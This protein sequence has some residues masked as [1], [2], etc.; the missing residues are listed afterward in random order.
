MWSIFKKTTYQPLVHATRLGVKRAQPWVFLVILIV[1][2]IAFRE[3]L[4]D[5]MKADTGGLI[6]VD[7]PE[8][9]SRERLVN[10]RFKQFAWLDGQLKTM[11]EQPF[12][13]QVVADMRDVY[14]AQAKVA[15]GA[16]PQEKPSGST[17]D[18]QQDQVDQARS[19]ATSS[20]VEEFRD[21]LVYREEI[22][23]EIMETLLD[24]RHDIKGNTL[25]RLKFDTSIIPHRD[26]NSWAIVLVELSRS[27]HN[28]EDQSPKDMCRQTGL[29]EIYE[30]WIR[31]TERS[32]LE[33]LSNRVK[34][35]R[36]KNATAE[37][38]LDFYR[39]LD[40]AVTK[41]GG[42]ND[43][44]SSKVSEISESLSK[45]VFHTL[46]PPGREPSSYFFPRQKP[47]DGTG[48]KPQGGTK[49]KPQDGT[50]QKAQDG[51]KPKIDP[52]DDSA[53]DKIR[54]A[55]HKYI[56]AKFL[57]A[58][59]HGDDTG[60]IW[61]AD[62]LASV[63]FEQN[64]KNRFQKWLGYVR[65]ACTA[66]EKK[67]GK[68]HAHPQSGKGQPDGTVQVNK[69]RCGEATFWKHLLY[70]P[71]EPSQ[72]EPPKLAK[73]A[74]DREVELFGEA[75]ADYLLYKFGSIHKLRDLA[76]FS[77]VG[78]EIG[79][80]RISVRKC[81]SRGLRIEITRSDEECNNESHSG[82]NR[83]RRTVSVP[84]KFMRRLQPEEIFSY[85]IT[86]KESAQR[87]S[88]LASSQ[89]V[90][91]LLLAINMASKVVANPLQADVATDFI[92][93]SQQLIHQIKRQPLIV[94]FGRA[95]DGSKK[96]S[97]EFGWLVG[98][99]FALLKGDGQTNMDIDFRH[100]PIQNALSAVISVPSWWK[101]TKLKV[102]TC[103]VSP[104]DAGLFPIGETGNRP[105]CPRNTKRF[106]KNRKPIQYEVRLPGSAIEIS[107]K[108]GYQ[109]GRTPYID[110]NAPDSLGSFYVGQKNAP[111]LIPGGQLWR[112]TVVTMGAQEAN[113]IVVLPNMRGIVAIFDEIKEPI[114]WSSRDK[115]S[116][117]AEMEVIVWT[118]E[119]QA[120]SRYA[121]IY[122]TQEHYNKT[123]KC[124]PYSER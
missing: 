68:E 54:P 12:G 53:Y 18:N 85:A 57:Q 63:H 108:L 16:P 52:Y 20:P 22:R 115:N 93:Q 114:R 101:A 87:I 75:V 14:R 123:K 99:K 43:A 97:T 95:A 89:R 113:R 103:W 118:S 34:N 124:T 51:T 29:A 7:S 81:D 30:E 9:Y 8:V 73:R 77:L 112:S 94:G 79:L 58:K 36:Q 37:D 109:I 70:S 120:S 11:H 121:Q 104:N 100:V 76:R 98:P 21:K 84:D 83:A 47:Q 64:R 46:S 96:I 110:S 6:L 17:E 62:L 69:N 55:V 25:Y 86:P 23:S 102:S 24:D 66:Y 40:L 72:T 82:N 49:P 59:K 28:P 88:E 5:W 122:Q 56:V 33:Q 119:G 26:T 71:D 4:F 60:S 2:V 105:I 45:I 15:M 106:Y 74:A 10:D 92:Q 35:F 78:C 32:L 117:I 41:W 116:C 65:Q 111:L 27:C 44:N 39:F 90:T 3:P 50:G 67:R 38:L 61:Q 13:N 48:Q 107:R 1:L 80:C 31:E 19:K 42:Q 91:Q